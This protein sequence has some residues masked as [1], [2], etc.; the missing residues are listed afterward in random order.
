LKCFL[1]FLFDVVS[2]FL[3]VDKMQ[4]WL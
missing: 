3:V 1:L 2:G 4:E